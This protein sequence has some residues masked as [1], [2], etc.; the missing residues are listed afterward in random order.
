MTKET[1]G[2]WI[3]NIPQ[4]DIE[5]VSDGNV[6]VTDTSDM[7]GDHTVVLHPIHLRL[8][9]EKLG[10]VGAMSDTEAQAL[11]MVDKLVRRMGVLH[12]RIKQMDEW[13]W[14]APDHED[15]D[16]TTEIWYSAA[17]LELSREFQAEIAES[18]AVS[19]SRRTDWV[20]AANPG[21]ADKQTQT[22]P[23]GNPPGSSRTSQA[24]V[25]FKGPKTQPTEAQQ[26]LRSGL[27]GDGDQP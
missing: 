14:A 24:P 20:A 23:T 2:G 10:L 6:H 27:F 3:E 17:T 4:V 18:G 11:R 12:E 26:A 13:L 8:I 15:A 19:T 16:I 25:K 5:L 7:N 9:A 1:N 21:V 22:K